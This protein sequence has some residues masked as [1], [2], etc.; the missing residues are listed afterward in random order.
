MPATA[1]LGARA[2]ETAR[3][4]S[5]EVIDATSEF[6]EDNPGRAATYAALALLAIAGITAYATSSS[7]SS[8]SGAD[9][10]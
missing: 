9:Q 2:I 10:S 4:R 3:E 6:V 1:E 8:G 7:S 5:R